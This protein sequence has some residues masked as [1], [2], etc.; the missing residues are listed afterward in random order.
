MQSLL[1]ARDP[2]YPDSE[3]SG[4]A[5]F[6]GIVICICGNVIISFALNLQRLAHERIQ[7]K[8]VT[9]QKQQSQGPENNGTRQHSATTAKID[10]HLH[11][12]YEGTLYLKSSL[13]WTGLV[14][15]A[16]GETGNFVAC[17]LLSDP[18]IDCRWI[19]AG[20]HRCSARDCG[21]S[22]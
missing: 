6:I 3:S 15:M 12:Y 18:R 11:T 10:D 2:N 13:W 17:N 5:T 21:N 9:K 14:L 16:I 8:L 20:I 4:W 1:R 22:L 19:C 7:R